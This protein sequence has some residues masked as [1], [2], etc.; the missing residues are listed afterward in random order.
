MPKPIGD[1]TD[2]FHRLC[3]M[4]VRSW[5]QLEF[6]LFTLVARLLQIDQFRARVVLTSLSG[7]RAKRELISRLGETFLDEENL[8]QFRRLIRRLR[9]L[10]PSRNVVAHSLIVGGG[11]DGERQIMDDTFDDSGALVHNFSALPLNELRV[12]A[13]SIDSLQR[14]TIAFVLGDELRVHA[15]PKTQRKQP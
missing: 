3:G 12:L 1:D 5:A 6:S 8:P 9:R 7:F 13:R 10:A 15:L 2:E 14:D 11:E 4:V